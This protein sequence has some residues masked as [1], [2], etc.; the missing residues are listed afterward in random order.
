MGGLASPGTPLLNIVQLTF[1]EVSAELSAVEAV[2]LEQARSLRFEYEDAGYT[3]Q[4]QHLL[5]VTIWPP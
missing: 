2:S 5:P 3:L 1:P 4:L